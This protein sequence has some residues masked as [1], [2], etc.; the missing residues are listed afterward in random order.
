MQV[1]CHWPKACIPSAAAAA[2]AAV[3]FQTT[4]VKC[5][6]LEALSERAL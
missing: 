5:H 1:L 6:V 4:L 2:A 3:V